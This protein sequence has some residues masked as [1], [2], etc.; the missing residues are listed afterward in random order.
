MPSEGYGVLSMAHDATSA[1]YSWI[2]SLCCSVS[3]TTETVKINERTLRVVRLLAEGGFS[4]VYLVECGTEKYALKKVLAQLPEQSD[5][6]HWEIKVHTSLNHP[7]IMPLIDHAVVPA[8]NG[9]EEFLLL[10]PLYPNGSL[11]DRCIK[12][13]E[14][15][16]RMPE[17]VCLR[18]FQQ[19]LQGV[20]ALHEHQPPWAHRDI[21]PANVL[22]GENDVPVLMDF[23]SVTTA[24]RKIGSRTEALLLQEDAAQNCSMPYRA[25]E[26]FD[27]PSDCTI[28]ERTDV[29]S[30]GATLYAMA[31]Y[32]S[33]FECTFQGNDQRVVECSHLRVIGG[34]QFPTDMEYS[35]EFRQLIEWQLTVDPQKRPTVHQVAARVTAMLGKS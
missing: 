24:R 21:K 12:H 14:A 18:I 15:G 2:L 22:L 13:M 19:I 5:A 29:F 6:A 28:D 25:P 8:A 3:C 32:Y 27:V 17:R 23:G 10:M 1:V 26:L 30:L 34:A 11:L 20:C 31:F 9:A 16:T 35:A 33:P 7:N 4:F